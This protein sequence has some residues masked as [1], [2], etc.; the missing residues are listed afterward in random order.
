MGYLGYAYYVENAE[1]LK[2]VE[3]NGGNGCVPPTDANINQGTYSPL[4]RPLFIYVRK[5]A[6][7]TPHIAEFI[8]YYLSAHGQGLAAEVGYIPFPQ[9]VYDLAL[10]KFE[11]GTVGTAYSEAR[12]PM[13]GPVEEV[14]ANSQ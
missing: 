1:R 9:T 6:A 7:G 3:I 2:A 5:D 14:L 10:A 11:N 8:R 4:S 13:E 12:I